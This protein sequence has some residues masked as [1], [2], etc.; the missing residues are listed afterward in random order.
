MKITE[1]EGYGFIRLLLFLK[2]KNEVKISEIPKL[3]NMSSRTLYRI[4]DKMKKLNLIESKKQEV[5]PFSNVLCL[6]DKGRRVADLL[7]E[8]ERVLEE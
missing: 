8:I 7:S 5:F 3:V 4:I 6:T 1:L 2:E